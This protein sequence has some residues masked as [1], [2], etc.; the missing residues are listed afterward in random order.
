MAEHARTAPNV[1]LM[2][3]VRRVAN[4]VQLTLGASYASAY[5]LYAF[6]RLT[7]GDHDQVVSGNHDPKDLGGGMATVVVRL[8]HAVATIAAI[9]GPWAAVPFAALTLAGLARRARPSVAPRPRPVWSLA[10]L[11]TSLAVLVIGLASGIDH[12]IR[13]WILD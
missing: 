13:H 10:A 12:E 6:A 8:L 5:A 9:V 4:A 3:S 7:I 11:G 2:T 1:E